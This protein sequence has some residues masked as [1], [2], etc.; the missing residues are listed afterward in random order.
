M[1]VISSFAVVFDILCKIRL[2]KSQRRKRARFKLFSFFVP[3]EKKRNKFICVDLFFL[4]LVLHF[5]CYFFF[6]N[7]VNVEDCLEA[8]E[9]EKNT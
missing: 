9:S 4:S 8:Y 3:T 6:Q 5:A 1:C 7:Y 2:E